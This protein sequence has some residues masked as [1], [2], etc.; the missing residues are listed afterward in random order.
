MTFDLWFENK[1]PSQRMLRIAGA[2]VPD[3]CNKRDKIARSFL[4]DGKFQERRT[5]RIRGV[6]QTSDARLVGGFFDFSKNFASGIRKFHYTAFRSKI[7]SSKS[8]CV[9]FEAFLTKDCDFW[10]R[11]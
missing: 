7:V 5:L 6:N 3:S 8:R 11:K 9:E 4:F 10:R 2:N 1:N